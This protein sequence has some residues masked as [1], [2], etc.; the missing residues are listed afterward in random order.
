[1]KL[2]VATYQK[3]D[4][5]QYKAAF[6]YLSDEGSTLSAEKIVDTLRAFSLNVDAIQQQRSQYT[7][8]Q[9]Y[10]MLCVGDEDRV[11]RR[12]SISTSLAGSMHSFRRSNKQLATS[13]KKEAA[14]EHSESDSEIS[15]QAVAD[16]SPRNNIA[17][18]LESAR[19]WIKDDLPFVKS[20][21]PKNHVHLKPRSR[22]LWESR[23][24]RPAVRRADH[25]AGFT[26]STPRSCVDGPRNPYVFNQ[27][28][29]AHQPRKPI[30]KLAPI[31][32]RPR[33]PDFVRNRDP[34]TE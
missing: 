9:F 3:Q 1:M 11:L 21:E 26:S 33:L 22:E 7:Y 20:H 25:V 6:A 8:Q 18:I 27:S 19:T 4:T 30:E 16:S 15:Q 10:S 13:L 14:D 24:E 5:T 23:H 31:E 34:V 17:G 29:T 2:L 28:K 12:K 32:R